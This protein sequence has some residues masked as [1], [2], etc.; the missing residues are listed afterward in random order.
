MTNARTK[1]SGWLYRITLG[2]LMLGTVRYA[3]FVYDQ[4]LAAI[5]VPADEVFW[6]AFASVMSGA[7]T[8]AF[9][10]LAMLVRSGAVVWLL[11]LQFAQMVFLLVPTYVFLK[12]TGPAL[13]SLAIV[14][15]ILALGI[16]L[17]TYLMRRDEIRHA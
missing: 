7:G 15:A 12:A 14:L 5:N 1:I 10:T 13:I 8:L 6:T 17:F 11:G 2:L 9:A 4:M 16:V 3:Q